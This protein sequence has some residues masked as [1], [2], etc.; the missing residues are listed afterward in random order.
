MANSS[1]AQKNEM[2]EK[3]C[4]F[5]YTVESKNGNVIKHIDLIYSKYNTIHKY[6]HVSKDVYL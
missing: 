4:W 1:E 3:H 5:M 6:L 2:Y